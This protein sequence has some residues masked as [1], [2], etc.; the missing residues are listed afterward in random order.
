MEFN[1]YKIARWTLLIRRPVQAIFSFIS[2]IFFATSSQLSILW[3]IS[4]QLPISSNAID[5]VYMFTGKPKTRYMHVRLQYLWLCAF[6]HLLVFFQNKVMFV[7]CLWSGTIDSYC[8]NKSYILTPHK[9]K[10]TKD[11]IKTINMG[12][13]SLLWITYSFLIYILLVVAFFVISHKYILRSQRT[14]HKILYQG[15]H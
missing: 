3:V 6:T 1:E 8:V 2:W 15:G 13:W 5:R 9:K 12:L 4:L 7:F 11:K 14:L 10:K